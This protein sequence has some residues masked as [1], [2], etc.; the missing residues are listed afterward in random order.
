M[1]HAPR[2]LL[3]ALSL[4]LF[5]CGGSQAT[6]RAV[7][8][9][10]AEHE[11]VFENG[12]DMVQDPSALGGGW[13]TS[14]EEELDQRVTLADAVALVT[15]TTIRTDTDLER[16]DTLR[17]VAHVEREYLGELD[18]EVTFSVAEGEAGYGTV[19]S[20]ERRLLDVQ[21]IAFVKWQRE[22][23]GRLRVR[24][25]LSPATNAVARRVRTLLRDRRQVREHDG[26]RRTV[27]IYR[28]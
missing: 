5:A 15:V 1:A 28:N 27:I 16:R 19:E 9:F 24:W 20:N 17:L 4:C 25:H 11:S 7:T 14:W 26:T 21:F 13:L 10:T 2:S 6:E 18:D 22:E 12:L 8:A 23:D 3:L